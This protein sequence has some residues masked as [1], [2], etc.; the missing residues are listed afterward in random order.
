MTPKLKAKNNSMR[1]KNSALTDSDE[2]GE[3]S[4][5]EAEAE[6]IANENGVNGKVG[7]TDEKENAATHVQ[8]PSPKITEAEVPIKEVMIATVKKASGTGKNIDTPSTG[9]PNSEKTEV[10]SMRMTG[11]DRK[12]KRFYHTTRFVQGGSS[13]PSDRDESSEPSFRPDVKRR[14][15]SDFDNSST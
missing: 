11:I 14:I 1:W 5:S 6:A 12:R 2:G 7:M 8:C 9:M 13:G 15:S 10:P 4:N 3:D